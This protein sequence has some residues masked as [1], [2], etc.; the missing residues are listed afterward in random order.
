MKA[1][2]QNVKVSTLK[3]QE[4]GLCGLAVIQACALKD[5]DGLEETIKH[6]VKIKDVYKPNREK[7]KLLMK[8]YKKFIKIYKHV[9]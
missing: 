7:H 2:M 5:Y 3:S 4:G 8:K 1:D 9:K 6:F